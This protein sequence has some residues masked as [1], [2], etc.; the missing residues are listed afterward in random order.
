VT[1]SHREH[2]NELI[3]TLARVFGFHTYDRTCDYC[4]E[5]CVMTHI[6]TADLVMCGDCVCKKAGIQQ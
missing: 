3:T 4:G 2:E 1:D 6:S 5:V